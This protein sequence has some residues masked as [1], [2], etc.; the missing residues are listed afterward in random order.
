MASNK[1]PNLGLDLWQP[2]DYFKRGEINEN[3]SKVDDKIG[4]L[5]GN[6]NSNTSQLADIKTVTPKRQGNETTDDLAL[7]RAIQKCID[8]K[9]G[10]I[11]WNGT[12]E[13]TNPLVIRSEYVNIVGNGEQS[14]IKFVSVTEQRSVIT[15]DYP[16]GY[17]LRHAQYENFR[18]NA[19]NKAKH[20]LLLGDTKPVVE[21][22][23]RNIV[24]E[25]S[26]DYGIV[27][28]ATQNS[29]FELLNTFNCAGCIS[30]LNGAGNNTFYRCDFSN[31]LTKHHIYMNKDINYGCSAMNLFGNRPSHNKFRDCI[32]EH[33]AGGYVIYCENGRRNK[34]D[35]Y[36][37]AISENT[38]CFY[39][40]SDSQYNKLDDISLS[41]NNK[42]FDVLTTTGYKNA[43]INSFIENCQATY[44]VVATNRTIWRHNEISS[45]TPLQFNITGDS[46]ILEVDRFLERNE[47]TS[48]LFPASVTKK[49]KFYFNDNNELGFAFKSKN[50]KIKLIEVDDEITYANTF[51]SVTS[52]TVPLVLPKAGTWM[53]NLYLY[54]G[55]ANQGFVG[56]WNVSFKKRST[57]SLLDITPIVAKTHGSGLTIG[58][59]TID[60][61]GNFN[62]TI[63]SDTSTTF[64]VIA[65]AICEMAITI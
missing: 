40:N 44:Y 47:S 11:Q 28:D 23:F 36:E 34:F 30:L 4:I 2:D 25:N 60:A 46:L 24:L 15:L 52:C 54:K 64:K 59:P 65:K 13:I 29:Y 31:S 45:S 61:D 41:Y 58:T 53:V 48:S 63:S 27:L 20:C 10:K 35:K 39:F 22:V 6:V 9:G 3:F 62:I 37:V 56:K 51:S 21:S 32:S 42:T 43:I 17:G 8:L 33:G 14:I 5:Q 7:Q 18:I 38:G 49:A 19:D 55:D 57:N 26:T 50:S 12:L 16:S 1:T